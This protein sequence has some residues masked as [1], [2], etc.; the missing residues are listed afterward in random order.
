HSGVFDLSGQ[1]GI[2]TGAAAGIGEAIA[3]R[4]AS[5]GAKIAVVD[6]NQSGAEEDA[7]R[8]AAEVIERAGRIDILVNNAGIAGTAAPL[9]EQ[10][11]EDWQRCIAINLT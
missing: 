10:T 9:W 4:L 2:V 6:L 5:A 11:D 8:V 1:V 3:R 7:R